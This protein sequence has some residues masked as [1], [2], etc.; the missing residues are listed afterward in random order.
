VAAAPAEQ[1]RPFAPDEPPLPSKEETLRTIREE[2]ARKQMQIDEQF[3]DQLDQIRARDDEDRRK[4]REE[5]ADIVSQFGKQAGPE[6]EKLVMRS[7]RIEDPKKR[8]LAHRIMYSP[9]LPQKTKVQ[10]LRMIGMPEAFILD[11]Y[12]ANTINKRTG[13][14]NGPRDRNDVWS[15]AAH[16][17]LR[18]DLTDPVRDPRS[19]SSPGRA[20][21]PAQRPAVGVRSAARGPA[22]SQ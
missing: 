7:G 11:D 16:L 19:A 10:Q 14:R 4:F 6:I 5:L 9:Q 15:Q 17:L 2:A 20:G 22:R 13:S 8:A 21:Q 18:F 3:E 1:E 12:L